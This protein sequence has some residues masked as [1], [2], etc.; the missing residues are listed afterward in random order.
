[1]IKIYIR[2]IGR[3]FEEWKDFGFAQA[4]ETYR[5]YIIAEKIER[6]HIHATIVYAVLK[7]INY[8]QTLFYAEECEKWRKEK[9]SL[10]KNEIM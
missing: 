7:K 4:I 10:D 9:Y 1:M 8:N 3:F 5:N 2:E 6:M